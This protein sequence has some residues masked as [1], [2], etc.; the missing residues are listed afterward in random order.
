MGSRRLP[1]PQFRAMAD[2]QLSYTAPDFVFPD[3]DLDLQLSAKHSLAI[4]SKAA[5]I[6]FACL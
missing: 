6:F 2:Q 4:A 3:Y 1:H 5:E